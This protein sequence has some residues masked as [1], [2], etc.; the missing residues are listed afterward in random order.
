MQK[1]STV[2]KLQM[3]DTGV[4]I[5]ST[6]KVIIVGGFWGKMKMGFLVLSSFS[7]CKLKHLGP[8]YFAVYI[9]FIMIPCCLSIFFPMPC[10]WIWKQKVSL[11]WA[12]DFFLKLFCFSIRTISKFFAKLLFI[13][14]KK[15]QPHSL[16]FDKQSMQSSHKKYD[17]KVTSA[18][19]HVSCDRNPSCSCYKPLTESN[20]HNNCLWG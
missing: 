4:S 2:I 17:E 5:K 9:N 13:L 8:T 7:Y 18:Q 15:R 3:A 14:K 19:D 6:E 1:I 12:T 10:T 16:S 11:I 20:R